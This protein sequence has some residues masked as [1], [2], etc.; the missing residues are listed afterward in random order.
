M[1]IIV[2]VKQVPNTANIKIDPQTN[3]LIR[4]D[5]ESILN[6]YDGFALEAA[7]RIRDELPDTGIFVLSMGPPQAGN[8][9]RECLAVAADT[10]Y[11]ATDR[12]FGGSD[13]L[14]TGYI[15]SECIKKIEELEAVKFDAVFCG[16]QAI[17]GDT[18]QTGPMI[19][20][21]L[22]LPQITGALT[23]RY[24]DGG[25]NVLREAENCRQL[26]R[27]GFPCLVTFTKPNFDPRFPTVGRKLAARKAEIRH[28]GIA[29]IP[30]IDTAK[31]GLNGSPTKVRKT[32]VMPARNG[33][34]TVKEETVKATAA[35]LVRL[36]A[37]RGIL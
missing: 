31:I 20:E 28:L 11:L 1:N 27:V 19:A 33:G 18:A 30:D 17:D 12:L 37:N 2:C 13:T 23:C 24:N 36:L 6:T 16:K 10:A 25:L 8:A 9:L 29:D 14:A 32:F 3:T 22:G 21:F 15:L 5:V 26:M 34:V 7:A 4:T 35:K